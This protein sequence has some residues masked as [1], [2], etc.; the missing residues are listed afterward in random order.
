MAITLTQLT[1]FAAVAK[2]GGFSVAART[3]GVAQSAVSQSIAALEQEL[4]AKL[5]D[6]TSRSCRL[7]KLGE[8]F[9]VDAERIVKDLDAAVQRT[10]RSA[11]RG[12][13]RLVVGMTGGLSSLL[14]E[15]L[16]RE[17][18]QGALAL[19][20]VIME[21]S[22]GR[23]RELLLEGRIDC[24]LTYNVQDNDPQLRSQH[25]AYEPMHLIAHPELMARH[26]RPG[27]LD[28]AQIA[29]FP[30]FLPS[31]FRE[32]GAGQL[33]M[34]EAQAHGV[35]LDIRYELQSTTIIR[36]LLMQDMLATVI[37]LGSVVDDVAGGALQARVVAL[38]AF[39]RAIGLAILS[40]RPYGPLETALL[41]RIRQIA[42][43]FLM[44]CGI[45]RT[46]PQE[47]QAPDLERFRELRS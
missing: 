34:R 27:P 28:L 44:P 17:A 7:T 47:L 9:L 5:L 6:R 41:G 24:A 20:L 29:R 11:G 16:L 33:L 43:D 13:Q 14:T 18:P 46:S 23:L 19:D 15:R 25:V 26:L 8:A 21:G 42:D 3:L 40:S 39:A 31:V 10:R 4:D 2:A 36:R 45:W 12:G 1:H 37:G 32:A 35:R 38:P 30:L 22:V